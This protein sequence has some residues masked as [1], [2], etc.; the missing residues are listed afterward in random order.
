[1]AIRS[2]RREAMEQI[3]KLQKNGMSEDLTKDAE[4]SIQEITDRYIGI[5]DKHLGTKEK[6][7]MTV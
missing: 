1:V 6:E 7:I 2:I 5:V 3:K 4:E